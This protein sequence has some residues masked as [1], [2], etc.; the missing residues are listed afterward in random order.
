[1]IAYGKWNYEYDEADTRLVRNVK[2][3]RIVNRDRTGTADR[4]ELEIVDLFGSKYNRWLWV[5]CENNGPRI[6]KIGRIEGRKRIWHS[7]W[8]STLTNGRG[9]SAWLYN[10]NA[11]IMLYDMLPELDALH[12]SRVVGIKHSTLVKKYGRRE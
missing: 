3:V 10:E 4:Y 8:A 1:M 9:E 5:W 12:L 7:D 11:N 6:T 2:S